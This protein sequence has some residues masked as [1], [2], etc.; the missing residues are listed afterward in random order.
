MAWC[1]IGNKPLSEMMVL[2]ATDGPVC[3][4]IDAC[5]FV[6]WLTHCDLLTPYGVGRSW[7]VLVQ[8]MACLPDGITLTTVD[9]PSARSSG[10]YSRVIGTWILKTLGLKFAHLKSHP[11]LPG[12]NGLIVCCQ[13]II[14]SNADL[15]LEWYFNA[16]Y[17]HIY[18]S[19]SFLTKS[20]E[21]IYWVSWSD[22]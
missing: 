17:H 10:I 3:Q 19:A 9:L 1:Q 7:P 13:A 14:L 4:Y 8:V 5:W 15:P 20:K 6:C 21:N 18:F 16:M 2:F 22:R 11:L 12:D